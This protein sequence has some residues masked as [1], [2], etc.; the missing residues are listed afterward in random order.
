M[1][2]QYLRIKGEFPDMLL[3]Y[4]MGDF[5]ELFFDDA[6]RAAQLLDITLTKRGQSAGKPIPMAGVPYHAAENYLAKLVRLGESVAICEQ[7]GDPAASKGPVERK[8]VRIITPGT[9]TDESLLEERQ[10]NLL[11]AL[12]QVD[13]K[14]GLATL[15]LA[16]GRFI[17]QQFSGLEALQGELER[18]RPV[19][20]LLEED[21]PIAER[22]GLKRGIT[23]RP[24]WHFDLASAE[25]LLTRQF[26]TRDLGGFGCN[27]QPLA[28]AAA[29]CLLQYVAETQRSAL[30]HIRSLRTERRE[31]AIIIDAAT[32]RN[33]E[34]DHSLS[35]Q[36]QHTLAGIMDRTATA[37]GSRMLRRWINR[38]LRNRQAVAQRHTAIEELLEQRAFPELRESL[39]EIGDIERILTRVALK[40]ARPRDLATLRDTLDVLPALQSQLAPLQSPLLT[41]LARQIDTHPEEHALLARTIIEQPP[42]LIRNGGVL[43]AGF[44]EQLDELRNLSQNADQ[45]L[46][47]LEARERERTGIT[48]L[49]VSY[50]RVHGYYIEISRSQSENAPEDYIRR[51]TL[52]GAERFIT[53]ELKK[54]EDQVLSARERSLAREKALY[55]QLLEQLAESLAALQQC[56]EGLASLDILC[57]L[58][59][60][61]ESLNLCRPELSDESGMQISD[62]RHPVVEQVSHEPFIANSIELDEQRRILIITG[63]NMGGKST[64]MRQIAIIALL[65]Y[66]GSFVPASALRI[67]PI[68]RIFSRIGASDDLAGGR[69]TF[70]VEMEETA[71]ILHN[72]T[73]QSL[74]LMDEIGRGT[75]TFDGLSLAWSCAVELATKIHAFTLFA[76]HYFELTT[77]PEE[78]PGIVNVH[79]DAV[80]HGDS[81]V[82]LHAVREGPA[83]QSYGLQVAALAGV[84][85]AVIQ[86]ARQRL[87]E[88]EQAAQQHAD[89]QQN[90]LPLLFQE[91]PQNSVVEQALLE[92]NPDNLTPRQ[93][94]EQIYRL[95]T[96]CQT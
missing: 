19:E 71:N 37:M 91:T 25:Q 8:V 18:L 94:L 7:I 65:A 52:K 30:P 55:E 50:N 79:L 11:A 66:C 33:L 9:L 51:Q 2:Q 87:E 96:L 76:T 89:Q 41:E 69:S 57:N 60:R 5:Y 85:K 82:F 16:S 49:K 80:E 59:E 17:V 39:K 40:S 77:L 75:S 47:D 92:I 12:N 62:G 24:A 74:V 61:A 83:N 32:R 73:D 43:A 13:D 23:H 93:A 84:P 6:E 90:Q 68:D 58:A 42:M 53:P 54:F 35:N 1:M 56:A 20:L 15:D 29:G 48:S 26:G 64:F 36:P 22:L 27:D 3:F 86:R 38:P 70:M 14:F 78:Y 81:I 4:R 72:A 21:N 34:L 45:F 95:K 46:L 67:G 10:E 88:L 44:D 28:L 63:P 31:D